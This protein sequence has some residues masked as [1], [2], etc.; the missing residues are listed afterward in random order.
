VDD[1]RLAPVVPDDEGI[2]YVEDLRT[3]GA[4]GFTDERLLVV[5]DDGESSSV[6]L[7]DVESV[8]LQDLDWFEAVLG[9]ALLGF[10][11]A[12]LDRSVPLAALFVAL[13]AGSLYLTYRKR[14]RAQVSVHSRAK[15]L[16]VYPA[17]SQ[18]FYDAFE[19]ALDDYRARLDREQ[20]GGERSPGG[21]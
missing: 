15:P 19:R 8:E 6:E 4:V 7:L 11:V 5:P 12:S 14:D 9:V 3:G 2:R 20:D 18:G 21:G 16:T 10:G 1:E 13:G 17:D